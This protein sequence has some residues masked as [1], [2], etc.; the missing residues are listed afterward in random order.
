MV[1]STFAFLPLFSRGPVSWGPHLL[2]FFFAL[3][4]SGFFH[5]FTMEATALGA[6][7][8]ILFNEEEKRYGGHLGM[9]A[10]LNIVSIQTCRTTMLKRICSS[11]LC[12]AGLCE[13]CLAKWRVVQGVF[14]LSGLRCF[15]VARSRGEGEDAFGGRRRSCPWGMSLGSSTLEASMFGQLRRG[16]TRR[17]TLREVVLRRWC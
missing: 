6:V 9:D 11:V 10:T 3:R 17:N 12:D 1:S 13:V 5:T 14:V 15:C 16:I 8:Y 7:F 2:P 4:A